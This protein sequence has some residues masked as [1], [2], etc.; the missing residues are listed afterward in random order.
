MGIQSTGIRSIRFMKNTQTKIVS[1]SGA[2]SRLLPWKVSLTLLSTKSTIISTASWVLLGTPDVAFFATRPN[3]Q[4][5]R[6]PRNTDQNIES[7]LI[8]IGLPAQWF[9][10]HSPVSDLQT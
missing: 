10:I 2:I 1:P 6:S 3:I 5:N 4:T 8:A 9:Q 7:T